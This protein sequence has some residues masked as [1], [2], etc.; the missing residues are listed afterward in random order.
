MND[1]STALTAVRTWPKP[2][3]PNTYWVAPGCLLAG[4][5]PAGATLAETTARLQKLLAA[6]V[7]LFVDLTAEGELSSYRTLFDY[8]QGEQTIRHIRHRIKDHDVPDSPQTMLQILD[9]I[10]AH[11]ANR[12]VAYVHCRAGIGRTGTAV[13]CYL[14]RSGLDADAALDR[15]NELW[16]ECERSRTWPS[17]PETEAQI[18][19]VRSWPT[20]DTK[21]SVKQAQSTPRAAAYAGALIGM[22][23]GDALGA[24]VVVPAA[25]AA[26]TPTAFVSDLIAGGP[27]DL[28]S[29]AWLAD[30]AMTRCLA[31]S[32]LACKT[33]NPEDQ[34]QR[35]LAWQRDGV[36]ASTGTALNV[37]NEVGKALAQWQ[38]TRKPIAG[39]HDPN[40]RDAHALARTLAAV[41]YFA[42]D[43]ARALLEAGEVARTTLQS[44]VVL[45]A[46]RAYAV[47]LL[48][49]LSKIDKETLVALKPSNNA[50]LLRRNRLKA[51][52]SQVMDGWWRGP[53]PPARGGRDALAVLGT[54]LWAFEQTD[55]YRDGVLLAVNSCSNAPSCGAVYGAL[56]GMYYG[57]QAIPK[58]WR[59]AVLQANELLGLAQRLTG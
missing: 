46:S 36:N 25:T 34:M 19:F 26:A 16:L 4:E 7:T 40:N 17:V 31:E 32:L 9:A 23:V 48:D 22:A 3:L 39:S 30:T 45:D 56:A 24:L 20:H 43:P 55:N 38:W 21:I 52:V 44:P 2:P 11:T 13:G 10:E 47:L 58:E 5:Y 53:T 37:P 27:F 18:E 49:A 50:Q 1:P 15:L 35:Y 8:V 28:P 59:N 54:A 12:G 51:P 41:L 57:L 42:G 29:G 14:V 6:G 33:S